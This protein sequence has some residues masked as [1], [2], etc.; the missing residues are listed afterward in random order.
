[1]NPV[2]VSQ[3][4]LG[5]HQRWR[6]TGNIEDRAR[7]MQCADWLVDNQTVYTVADKLVGVWFYPYDNVYFRASAPW[8]SGM[9]Q[10]QALSVLARAW[11]VDPKDV[12]LETARR[13]LATFSIDIQDKGVRSHYSP[14]EP[15]YEEVAVE[16]AAHILNGHLFAL[17]GLW[18]HVRTWGDEPAFE[19]L[20]SAIGALTNRLDRYDAK[21]W[22]RYSMLTRNQLAHTFYHDLHIKQLQY[23]G[24]EWGQPSWTVMAAKWEHYQTSKICKGVFAVVFRF[25]RGRRGLRTLARRARERNRDTRRVS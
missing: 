18:D 2:T 8:I 4:A 14:G 17:F 21:Y 1:L 16:P 19:A 25:H 15:C 24:N 9:A 6:R 7:L 13:S 10:G 22:S 12:Y 11:A 3:F 20:N 5:H 23:G